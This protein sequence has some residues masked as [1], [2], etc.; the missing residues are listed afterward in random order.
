LD[1]FSG[2]LADTFFPAVPDFPTSIVTA[3]GFNSPSSALEVL[4]TF[5]SPLETAHRAL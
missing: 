5:F 4:T 2:F 1:H 3:I